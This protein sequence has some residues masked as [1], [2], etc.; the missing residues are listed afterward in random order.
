MRHFHL[1]PFIRI[2]SKPNSAYEIKWHKFAKMTATPT[3]CTLVQTT[4]SHI[5]SHVL[6]HAL[7]TKK[8]I[9]VPTRSKPCRTLPLMMSCAV[10]LVLSVFRLVFFQLDLRL[11]HDG[12]STCE[13]T[14]T[15]KSDR[16]LSTRRVGSE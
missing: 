13:D 10:L 9:P 15:I 14:S 5:S 7:L 3:S 12:G 11:G 8:K 16:E 2:M 6:Y 4:R 1:N